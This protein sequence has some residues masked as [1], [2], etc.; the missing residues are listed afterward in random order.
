MSSYIGRFAPSPTGPL[1]FGSLIAATASYLQARH[2]GGSWLLRIEDLDPPREVPGASDHILAS[3]HTLGFIWDGPVLYQSRRH[4]IYQ[5]ALETL[6]AAGWVYPCA[7][8]RAEIA[9]SNVG[10]LRGAIYPG[11]C[12]QGLAPGRS[13]R[14]LRVRCDGTAIEFVDGVQ[15]AQQQRLADEIGDF[16]VRRAD[17]LFSYQLAV[18]VDDALQGV[19]EVVRGADL[20]DSTPRQIHMQ[21]LLKLPTPRYLHLPAAVNAH[22]EKLS[23]QTGAPPLALDQPSALL[24][25]ALAFLGQQPSA[26]L[27]DA[28][29]EACWQWAI[30]H[31]DMTRIP[32]APQRTAD[33][34]CADFGYHDFI[35]T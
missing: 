22:G 23:K 30:A 13:A 11:T 26:T 16:I 7:C 10:G 1:H 4:D 6:I 20:L 9:D 33:V 32:R 21:N 15:G 18:V 19:T 29:L 31:W 35:H 34:G 14:A 3:L 27:R 17:G 5:Q 12:R 8:T 25:A 2:H 24:C 28:S